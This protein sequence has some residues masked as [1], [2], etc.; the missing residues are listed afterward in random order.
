MS[1]V[2]AKSLIFSCLLCLLASCAGNV[3]VTSRGCK[4]SEAQM[5][6]E[7][8][9]FRVDYAWDKKVWSS[10]GVNLLRVKSLLAEKELDCTMVAKVRYELAQTFWDQLFSIFPFFSRMTIRVEVQKS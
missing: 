1:R 8:V 10:G 5:M 2:M 7:E 3:G 9:E 4:A 6:N